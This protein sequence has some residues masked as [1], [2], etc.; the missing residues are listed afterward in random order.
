ME[1][2]LKFSEQLSNVH[3]YLSAVEHTDTLIHFDYN[4]MK[5]KSRFSFFK[6]CHFINI[7]NIWRNHHNFF[8]C[9]PKYVA[10]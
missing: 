1:I 10:I 4:N 9:W 2:F 5:Y 8:E 3:F 6:L 7:T